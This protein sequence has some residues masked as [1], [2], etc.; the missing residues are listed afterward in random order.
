MD[1]ARWTQAQVTR[2][3]R[4]DRDL[5]TLCL[6][7]PRDF[8]A[9]QFTLL[10]REDPQARR[11]HVKRAYSIASAPG[12]PLEFFVVEVQGGALSPYLKSLKP[13]DPVWMGR[14][15]T[16]RFTLARVPDAPV[17]WMLATGTG[18]A[19]YIAML[20]EEEVFKR[21]GR[22]VLLHGARYARCLAYRAELE[23]IARHRPLSYVPVCSREDVYGA[24]RGRIPARLAD[25]TVAEAAGVALDPGEHQVMLCGNPAMIDEMVATLQ[26]RG[27]SVPTPSRPGQVHLERYW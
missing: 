10:A 25:G 22:V 9:G 4:W 2:H 5:F 21:F 23:A 14:R 19:P 7:A 12:E 6:D 18:L 11:G 24:L 15:T 26:A 20:R 13:G 17:L 16:G 1:P 8:Q 27:M 3:I